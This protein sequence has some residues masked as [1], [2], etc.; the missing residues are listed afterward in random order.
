MYVTARTAQT[1]ALGECGS[2]CSVVLTFARCAAYAVDQ[3]SDSTA[4]G[5]VPLVFEAD[6]VGAL[7]SLLWHF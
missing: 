6:G 2:G 4:V 3:D 1:A 5:W 7:A